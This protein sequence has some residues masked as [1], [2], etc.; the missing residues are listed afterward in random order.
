MNKPKKSKIIGYCLKECQ[1]GGKAVAMTTKRMRLHNC[2]DKFG[3]GFCAQFK[4]VKHDY[5]E[6]KERKKYLKRIK[7]MC[8]SIA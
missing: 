6:M 3:K 4:K 5:W 7:K 2:P 8:K 1:W